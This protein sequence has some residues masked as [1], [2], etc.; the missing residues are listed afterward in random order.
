MNRVEVVGPQVG[1][2]RRVVVLSLNFVFCFLSEDFNN[3]GKDWG[4]GRVWYLHNY[5]ERGVSC[6]NVSCSYSKGSYSFCF[7]VRETG[8]E[9]QVLCQLIRSSNLLEQTLDHIQSLFQKVS[10][11]LKKQE[12]PESSLFCDCY[13]VSDRPSKDP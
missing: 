5:C 6:V 8:D 3:R 9:S 4:W 7:G 11:R 13:L 12:D 10:Y 1:K 2:Y